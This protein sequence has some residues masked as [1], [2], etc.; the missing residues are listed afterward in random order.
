[1]TTGPS[2]ERVFD[3]LK[4]HMPTWDRLLGIAESE[5][6][7]IIAD[8]G[9]ANQKAPRVL[10]I[11]HRLR[12]DFGAVTL[13]PLMY[14]DT[15]SVETYLTSL[16]GVGLKTAKCVMMYSMGREVLPIDTHVARIAHRLGLAPPNT[17]KRSAELLEQSIAPDLRYD[18]HVNAVAHGRNVCRAHRP[19]CS[20]CVLVDFCE[21]S[22]SKRIG[23]RNRS[24]SPARPSRSPG[25]GRDC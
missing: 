17:S 19:V 11:A 25:S 4:S 2:Y 3:R 22:A 16:P 23:R 24:S 18:F 21:W 1:M 20:E 14:Q 9:L 8:A 5:L 7:S 6:K 13:V 12:Q 10:A 15:R